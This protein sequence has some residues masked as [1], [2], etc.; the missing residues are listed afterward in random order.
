MQS[1]L[2]KSVHIMIHR[3][4]ISSLAFAF[5]LVFQAAVVA[6]QIY[7][8]TDE[9]GKVRYS[10]SPPAQEA[11]VST[12]D[13]APGPTEAQRQQAEELL[14]QQTQASENYRA[15]RDAEKAESEAQKE[16]K[17]APEKKVAEEKTEDDSGSRNATRCTRNDI[18]WPC[19]PPPTH[20]P[21]R[22][23]K[24]KPGLPVQ[25]PILPDKPVNLPAKTMIKP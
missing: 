23:I 18:G 10:D 5:L 17:Q 13:I 4:F 19:T 16:K 22:P 21:I 6:Q 11:P 8:W 25:K 24:P 9:N 3:L 2:L 20:S 15:K 14:Q 1:E 12:V 7:K